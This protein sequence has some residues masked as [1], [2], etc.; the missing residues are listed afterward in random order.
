[1]T[2]HVHGLKEL[3]SFINSIMFKVNYTFF[4]LVASQWHFHVNINKIATVFYRKF[5]MELLIKSLYNNCCEH[6][7]A[8]QPCSNKNIIRLS[9]SLSS[10]CHAVHIKKVKS[11]HGQ[12]ST[13]CQFSCEKAFSKEEANLVWGGYCYGNS[14]SCRLWQSEED[15]Q[16]NRITLW[17]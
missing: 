5:L 12:L 6:G 13:I 10:P 11:P 7:L 3:I 2:S 16:V 8:L 15:T 14:N 4:D 17:W 9:F 1:M